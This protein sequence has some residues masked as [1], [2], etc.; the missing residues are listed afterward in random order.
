[1]S[2]ARCTLLEYAK[3]S[4]PLEVDAEQGVIRNVR[5]LGLVSANGRRY[6]PEAV[7]AA[8]A[9]YEGVVVNCDH[10][11]R[12]GEQIPADRRIGWLAGARLDPD[13]GVR[14]DLHLLTTHPMTARVIEAARRR[15]ELFG[16]SHNSTGRVERRDGEEVVV[17][18]LG[19][20]SVDLVADPATTHGLHESRGNRTMKRKVRD[21]IESLKAKRPGYARALREMA[22]AGVMSDQYEMDDPGEVPAAGGETADHEQALKQGFRAAIIACLDDD[23]LDLKAKVKKIAEILKTEEKMLGGDAAATEEA[24]EDPPAEEEDAKKTEARLRLQIRARDLLMESGVRPSLVLGKALDACRTEQEVREVIEAA[25]TTTTGSGARSAPGQ[26]V[27]ESRTADQI[28]A[29]ARQLASWL[30]SGN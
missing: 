18:I 30:R 3:G 20:E 23:S 10:P 24:E 22:A 2:A 11:A 5:V 26:R 16:L 12:P 19:V 4:G 29:D 25:R 15:P 28:P 6:L 14:A 17:E 9:L 13:G 21:L 7:R 8:L 27:Q 1:M